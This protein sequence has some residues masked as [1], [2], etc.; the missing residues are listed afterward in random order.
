MNATAEKLVSD[1]VA[2]ALSGIMAEHRT[3]ARLAGQ[4]AVR[5]K[6]PLAEIH[7]RVKSR[8]NVLREFVADIPIP[9]APSV[10]EL[11]ARWL[12]TLLSESKP[13]GLT[14][15]AR[16]L[17]IIVPPPRKAHAR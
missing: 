5:V 3:A 9:S 13:A 6:I 2:E 8:L 14:D 12:P 7:A 15:D 4:N 1:A 10:A 17:D 11:R 16:E